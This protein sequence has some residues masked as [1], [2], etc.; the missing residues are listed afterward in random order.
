MID[1]AK[2]GYLP[3]SLSEVSLTRLGIA[4]AAEEA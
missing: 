1:K 2:F 3:I 4:F